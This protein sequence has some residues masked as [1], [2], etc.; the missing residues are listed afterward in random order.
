[1]DTKLIYEQI[2]GKTQILLFFSS[3]TNQ[4]NGNNGNNNFIIKFETLIERKWKP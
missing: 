4:N 1:M 2:L 3:V